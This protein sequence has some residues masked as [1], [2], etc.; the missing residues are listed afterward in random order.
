VTSNVPFAAI[1]QG[2]NTLKLGEMAWR[3]PVALFLV[4]LLAWAHPILFR[5]PIA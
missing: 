5:V 3:I 2:R 1:A 4:A